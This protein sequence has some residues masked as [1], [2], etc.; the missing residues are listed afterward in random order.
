MT[1]ASWGLIDWPVPWRVCLH[2]P[3]SVRACTTQAHAQLWV[4]LNLHH[5]RRENI[6]R[7]AARRTLNLE[8]F[9]IQYIQYVR[10]CVFYVSLSSP[11][12]NEWTLLLRP[13]RGSL[14]C[15]DAGYEFMSV[16]VI[17]K[18]GSSSPICEARLWGFRRVSGTRAPALRARGHRCDETETK[19]SLMTRTQ[20]PSVVFPF[21]DACRQGGIVCC[22][23]EV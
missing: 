10:V 14:F 2:V 1:R 9:L 7:S 18:P 17:D 8:R 11:K 21:V 22:E 12:L 23:Q 19:T 20:T 15:S 13:V 5:L 3:G 6:C 16:E 4:Q